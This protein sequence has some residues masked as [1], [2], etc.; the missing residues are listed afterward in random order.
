MYRN[1]DNSIGTIHSCRLAR[2]CGKLR[3]FLRTELRCPAGGA[4]VDAD[5]RQPRAYGGMDDA[6]RPP[7]DPCSSCRT[8]RSRTRRRFPRQVGPIAQSANALRE[9][10]GG[11][12]RGAQARPD[13]RRRPPTAFTASASLDGVMFSM[14]AGAGGRAR[15]RSAT[16]MASACPPSA[17]GACP[18]R[19]RRN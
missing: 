16:G 14:R 9:L 1:K 12:G 3:F 17:S 2:S 5:G 18:R 10:A 8:D 15:C 7:R 6:A 13:E 4:V 11:R 19:A